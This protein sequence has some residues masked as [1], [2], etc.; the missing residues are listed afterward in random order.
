MSVLASIIVA[1]VAE[2][3]ISFVASLAVIVNEK[4]VRKFVHWFISFAVGALLAVVFFDVLPEAGRLI[5][6]ETAFS[7]V[8][9]GFLLFF[10]LEKFLSW[11][12]HHDD[13]EDVI[14][15]AVGYLI[16]TGDALHNFIDG[17]IIALS[18]GVSHSLGVI[19]TAA[20]LLHEIPQEVSDFV[21]MIHSGF[22]KRKALLYNVGVSLTTLLGALSGYLLLSLEQYLGPLLG[23]VA[24]NFLYLAASDLIP[25]LR[26]K[27]SSASSIAQLALILAGIAIVLGAGILLPE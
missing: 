2:A 5:G 16:S 24:G 10:M 19:T 3:L 22:S 11:Y 23:L 27:H 20:I 25:E 8:L 26:H 9:G 1:S 12:H 17:V 18:F 21:L 13:E 7:W 6:Y 14:S 4:R 15:P